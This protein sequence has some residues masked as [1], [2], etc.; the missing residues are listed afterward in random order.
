MGVDWTVNDFDIGE[1]GKRGK[2][3]GGKGRVLKID[4]DDL[5]DSTQ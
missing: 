3:D 1:K 5:G 2:D 4:G